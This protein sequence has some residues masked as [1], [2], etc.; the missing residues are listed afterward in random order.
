[1]TEKTE[2]LYANFKALAE[3]DSVSFCERQMADK[4]IDELKKL[5]FDVHED[6]A[7]NHYHGNAGNVYGFLKGTLPGTPILLSAHMDTVE[8]GIGKKVI[9]KDDERIMSGGDTVLGA[10]DI[11]GIIE[12]LEGIRTVQKKESHIGMLKCFFRL[13]RRSISREPLLLITAR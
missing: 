5:G 8:P 9:L 13:Q 10:D 2:N 3:I 1:M 11:C 6:E 12:I 4:L 7:G